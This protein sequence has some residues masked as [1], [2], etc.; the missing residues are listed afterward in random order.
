MTSTMK[1]CIPLIAALILAVP[2]MVGSTTLFRLSLEKMSKDAL[3][4]VQGHVAWTYADRPDPDGPPYT[5]TGVEVSRC[6]A[7]DCPDTVVL[8]HRGGK[9][10]GLHLYIP[11]MPTFVPGQEVLLFLEDD[12]ESVPGYMAVVGMVQGSFLLV[13]EPVSGQKLAVQQIGHVNMAAPDEAGNIVPIGAVKPIIEEVEAL[14]TEIK[15]LR[16]KGGVQ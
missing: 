8:R 9:A 1:K 15:K 3:L 11:G 16:A 7:G 10:G 5:F 4:V 6:V 12:Y 13:T 14:V 2:A